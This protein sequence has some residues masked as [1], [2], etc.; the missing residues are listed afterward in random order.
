MRGLEP[1][2]LA[3]RISFECTPQPAHPVR[4]FAARRVPFKAL[5]T[6]GG[7]PSILQA[8]GYAA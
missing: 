7:S 4:S 3:K 5:G 2:S 8:F 6:M 1:P